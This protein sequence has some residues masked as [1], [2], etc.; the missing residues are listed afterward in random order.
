M[1]VAPG[2]IAHATQ[3]WSISKLN[4]SMASLGSPN[5]GNDLLVIAVIREKG[6]AG[7]PTM[8]ILSPRFGPL[9]VHFDSRNIKVNGRE[10]TRGCHGMG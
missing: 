8:C 1:T 2:D 7:L 9:W 3:G 5:V 10:T 6:D 4:Q